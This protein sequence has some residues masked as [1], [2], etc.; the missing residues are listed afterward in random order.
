STSVGS[1]RPFD[2]IVSSRR[3]C[4]LL[5]TRAGFRGRIPVGTGPTAVPGPIPLR[6]LTTGAAAVYDKGDDPQTSPFRPSRDRNRD[7]TGP[8][9]H[10]RGRAAPDNGPP[11][12]GA[13]A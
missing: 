11:T 1:D 3:P 13:A 6:G 8:E 7:R 12:R 2:I 9:T 4:Q 5:Q 10:P